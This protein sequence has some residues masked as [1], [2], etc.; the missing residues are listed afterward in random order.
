M[1]GCKEVDIECL[2]EAAAEGW[3]LHV[4]IALFVARIDEWN[5]Q[6]TTA[7]VAAASRGHVRIV[8]LLLREGANP[9]APAVRLEPPLHAAIRHRH[10]AIVRALVKGGATIDEGALAVAANDPLMT[11]LLG[12]LST[13]R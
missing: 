1:A 12:A 4:Q 5:H 10:P 7:L 9:N 3:D 8:E 11:E 13:S 6:G 2:V